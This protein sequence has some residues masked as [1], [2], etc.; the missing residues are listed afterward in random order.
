M[1]SGEVPPL[2]LLLALFIVPRFIYK[3]GN[4]RYCI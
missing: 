1:Y 4:I 3:L 2:Y